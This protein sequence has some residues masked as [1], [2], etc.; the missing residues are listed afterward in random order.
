MRASPAVAAGA[1][2]VTGVAVLIWVAVLFWA[3]ERTVPT[4][5]AAAAV[6]TGEAM[7][8]WT[9]LSM[10]GATVIGVRS[11]D[12]ARTAAGAAFVGATANA[13]ATAE[14]DADA[15]APDGTAGTAWT[16]VSSLFVPLSP[17]SSPAPGSATG[18]AACGHAS[19]GSAVDE[20][21]APC[22]AATD[23]VVG[24]APGTEAV[25]VAVAVKKAPY[26][27]PKAQADSAAFAVVGCPPVRVG[28]GVATSAVKPEPCQPVAAVP[29]TFDV[30][31][32]DS[33]S[34]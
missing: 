3:A 22:G 7:L 2:V 21:T 19:S 1:A 8:T 29:A 24:A 25:A 20:V 28:R 30:C 12:A 9:G 5:P 14:A 10:A 33:A 32:V 13:E 15:D 4:G 17:E 26:V 23:D 16:A 27:P 11:P 31:G 18:V 6:A 34:L